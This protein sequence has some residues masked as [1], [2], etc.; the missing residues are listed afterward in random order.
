MVLLCG[1]TRAA[2]RGG[3]NILQDRVESDD[4]S[5]STTSLIVGALTDEQ[6]ASLSEGSKTEGTVQWNDCP[7]CHCGL[8]LRGS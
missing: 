6:D 5:N 8:D 7:I 1:T 2:L 3:D 4:D